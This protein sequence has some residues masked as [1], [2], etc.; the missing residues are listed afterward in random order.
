MK[1]AAE[2]QKWW[3][4]NQISCTVTV[5]P[6]ELDQLPE[7]LSYFEDDLKGISFLKEQ[8]DFANPPYEVLTEKQYQSRQDELK[9]KRVKFSTDGVGESFCDAE[10]RCLL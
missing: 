8:H 7:A 2:F 3:A 4:D 9:L 5:K 10:G 6:D 1:R